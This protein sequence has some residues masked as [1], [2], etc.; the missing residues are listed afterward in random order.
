MIIAKQ[1]ESIL[2]ELFQ[3]ILRSQNV[4]LLNE[5]VLFCRSTHSITGSLKYPWAVRVIDDWMATE[6]RVFCQVDTIGEPTDNMSIS[7]RE[8]TV[9]STPIDHPWDA[10]TIMID[11]HETLMELKKL[12]NSISEKTFVG[13]SFPAKNIV[14]ISFDDFAY[15][16][17][18]VSVEPKFVSYILKR[19]LNDQNCVKVVFSLSK[20]LV[21]IQQLIGDSVHFENVVEIRGTRVRKRLGSTQDVEKILTSA[22]CPGVEGIDQQVVESHTVT[23][24]CEWFTES[25]TSNLRELSKSWL[26]ID[27]DRQLCFEHDQWDIRPLPEDFV[28]V[29]ANDSRILVMLETRWRKEGIVPVETLSFDPFENS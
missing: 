27:H 16:I 25:R 9:L 23:Q 11:S 29:A 14:S 19:L 8:E 4:T 20:F 5:I 28:R 13:I 26:G 1:S 10:R 21:D 6:S 7:R 18:L 24:L 15:V 22:F 3:Q 12:L 2:K 17:D